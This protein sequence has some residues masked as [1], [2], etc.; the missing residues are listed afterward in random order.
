MSINRFG[1]SLGNMDDT[2]SRPSVGKT[3]LLADKFWCV[4]ETPECLWVFRVDKKNF[5]WAPFSASLL[6]TI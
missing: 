3:G 2:V 5:Q 1:H 4:L 6:K